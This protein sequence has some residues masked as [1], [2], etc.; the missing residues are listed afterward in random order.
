MLECGWSVTFRKIFDT[1]GCS[2]SAEWSNLVRVWYVEF[3]NEY[4]EESERCGG[5]RR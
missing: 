4:V 3:E 5:L 2:V 1:L